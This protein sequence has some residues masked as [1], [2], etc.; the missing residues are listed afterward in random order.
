MAGIAGELLEQAGKMKL[1]KACNLGEAIGVDFFIEMVGD[2][3]A[4]LHEFRHVLLPLVLREFPGVGDAVDIGPSDV[5][6][7]FQKP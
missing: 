7:E 4:D 5:D 2:I 3:V 1:G 6:E